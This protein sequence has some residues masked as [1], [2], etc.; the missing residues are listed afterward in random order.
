[1][2]SVRVPVVLGAVLLVVGGVACN[3]AGN[4]SAD[5]L[6][7]ACNQYDVLMANAA[8]SE[9]RLAAV[10][11]E[12][13]RMLAEPTI[14]DEQ[15][16]A[17]SELIRVA[18]LP[19]PSAEEARAAVRGLIFAPPPC[20]PMHQITIENRCAVLVLWTLEQGG[21]DTL[22]GS[23]EPSG[24]DAVYVAGNEG[25]QVQVVFTLPDGTLVEKRGVGSALLEPTDCQ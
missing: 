10:R 7:K 9:G 23:L 12:A 6:R 2:P 21:R 15:S 22:R 14:T 8:I 4:E 17:I 24:S 13:E 1:M 25:K 3:S 16:A 5:D 20:R 11:A 18:Q 19:S